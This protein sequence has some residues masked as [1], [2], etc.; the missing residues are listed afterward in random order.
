MGVD[1]SFRAQRDRQMGLDRGRA[2]KQQVA[3]TART[4]GCDEREAVSLG[5]AQEGRDAECAQ[6]VAFG[7]Q[8][9]AA[10]PLQRQR[11]QPDAIDPGF[12]VA[13]A[14][15]EGCSGQRSRRGGEGR[16]CIHSH[17]DGLP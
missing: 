2:Q 13:A 3:R 4:V 9:Y 5:E 11:H 16:A 10:A 17:P 15:S 12:D 7:G 8:R 14:Q 6:G 1:E